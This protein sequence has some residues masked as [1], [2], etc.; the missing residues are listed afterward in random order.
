M[1]KNKFKW[2]QK[3]E[4]GILNNS[5]NCEDIMITL[6]NYLVASAIVFSIGLAGIVLNRKNLIVLLMCI[7][8]ILL[9]VNT[10]FLAFGHFL[11]NRRR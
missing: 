1:L 10:N 4:L 3:S 5:L 7:E 9:A 6:S 8:L 2:I 11:R